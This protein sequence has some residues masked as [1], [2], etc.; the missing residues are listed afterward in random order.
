MSKKLSSYQK[1]KAKNAEL[2]REIFQLVR[3]PE[4]L[5]SQ[6]IRIRYNMKYDLL[7]SVWMGTIGRGD[8]PQGIFAQ[9]RKGDED[10]N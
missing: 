2:S 6:A 10:D 1:L 9:I 5:E 4:E 3:H 7:D 8:G